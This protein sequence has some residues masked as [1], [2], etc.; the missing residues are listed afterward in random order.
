MAV[1]QQCCGLPLLHRP[2]CTHLVPLLFNTHTCTRDEVVD[3]KL[4]SV[5]EI[6]T[7]MKFGPVTAGLQGQV[8]VTDG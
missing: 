6:C 5:G 2:S 8:P 3:E 7:V 4:V 1:P